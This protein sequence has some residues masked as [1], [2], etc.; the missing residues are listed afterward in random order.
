[1]SNSFLNFLYFVSMKLNIKWGI[2]ALLLVFYVAATS[3]K[4]P[5]KVCGCPG[6]NGMVGY[7]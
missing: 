2:I 5:N 6:K 4:G 7:N 3:C 1:M